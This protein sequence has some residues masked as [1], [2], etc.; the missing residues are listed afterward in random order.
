MWQAVEG[1]VSLLVACLPVIGGR[2]ISRWRHILTRSSTNRL[3]LN[4]QSKSVFGTSSTSRKSVYS[5]YEPGRVKDLGPY[6]LGDRSRISTTVTTGPLNPGVH[7][8]IDLSRESPELAEPVSL[9]QH[10]ARMG[11]RG[12]K[13]STPKA[14]DPN[15][16]TVRK[17]VYIREE[18]A[19]SPV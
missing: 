1:A 3:T 4:G 13:D 14:E 15:S 18:K 5:T 9:I 6:F 2:M 10:M 16:V 12:S 11:R 7:D 8:E 19:E 17:E